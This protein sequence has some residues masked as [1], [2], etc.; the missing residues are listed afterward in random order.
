MITTVFTFV[1]TIPA[2]SDYW[3]IEIYKRGGAEWT[4]GQNGHTG[5]KWLVEPISDTPRQK[6]VIVPSSQTNIRAEQL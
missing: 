2:N 4:V 1:F 5:W 6:P 3:R